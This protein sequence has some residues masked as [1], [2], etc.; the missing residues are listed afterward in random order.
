[1][2]LFPVFGVL[3]ALLTAG[4]AEIDIK[5][6]GAGPMLKPAGTF[7]VS[8][9][10]KDTND[11]RSP[12]TA[13]RT[14]NRGVRNLRAGDT[15]LIKGG[16]YEEGGI[17]LNLSSK[18]NIPDYKVQWGRPGS[19]IRVMGMPGEK[20]V[21]QGGKFFS[22]KGKGRSAVFKCRTA[23]TYDVVWEIPSQIRYQK[24]DFPQ[25][26]EKV[27]G[28]FHYDAKK[29]ELTVH[30]VEKA[31]E[32]I[33]VADERV[34][35]RLRGGYLH[36]ENVTFKNFHNCISVR[37]NAPVKK[38]EVRNVTVK[39]CG[40]FNAAQSG[41]DVEGGHHGLFIGNF[42]RDNGERGTILV[43]ADA[44]DNLL[45]GNWCGPSPVTE[46]HLK[47]YAYNYAFNFYKFNPGKRN[48]VIAN[49]MDDVFAFRWKS[50]PAES[51]FRNNF[52][53]GKFGVESPHVKVLVENNFIAGNLSWPGVSMNASDK[54]FKGFPMVF[55]NNVRKAA[56]FK[57]DDPMLAQAKKL[58]LPGRKY[59]MPALAFQELKAD[60]I[61]AGSAAVS[62]RTPECDGVVTVLYR[63]KGDRKWLQ[64]VCRQQGV[65]HMVGLAGLKPG[66][67]YEFFARF[68]GRRGDTGRSP[69]L[70]FRTPD[71]DRAPQVFEVGPGKMTLAQAS[72]AVLP[73]DTVKLLPGR[74]VGFFAPLRSG[75]PGKPITLQG[76]GATVDGLN[77]YNPLALLD[78]RHHI[79]ID[80]VRFAHPEYESRKGVISAMGSSF[81]KVRN[82]IS[83]HKLY[84]GPFFRGSG[85][86]FDLENNVSCGGDYALSFH[87]SRNVRIHRNSVINSALFSLIFWGGTGNFSMT[88]NIYYRFS[89]P[90]KTNPAMYFIG[91][92]GKIHSEGNV[93]WSPVKHQHI[94]GR[95]VTESRKMLKQ[96]TTLEEWQ[97][98]TG[99]DKT[100][101]HADP[102]FVDIAKGDFRLKPGSPAAGKGALVK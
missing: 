38:N 11:G 73:G 48:H 31:P 32:G 14:I 6:Y 83:I 45:T 94:G 59:D 79:V 5:A 77:F 8:T 71:R 101:L 80:N 78:D 2:K 67:E 63:K 49:V 53:N 92:T 40:V 56:E 102:Q 37:V 88:D 1:M 100:S 44:F 90:Q 99:M 60:F 28:T 52:V 18:G 75:L 19:P 57:C 96:S 3:G 21:V 87:A 86:D 43:E 93:F 46:R 16:V 22:A 85:H 12:E 89:V 35:I 41:L 10:G 30:F 62:C 7:Y 61:A 4:A 95:F 54:D 74:H 34:G 68:A 65:E 9:E 13:W 84:A 82:C 23:P 72:C 91:V 69:V 24:V 50:A 70:K 58:A 27:P 64:S 47:P 66:T 20:V 97:R 33:R 81:I 39:N 15:L 36:L 76:N 29:K 51:I 98:V 25:I 42:G 55:R 26:V 17:S